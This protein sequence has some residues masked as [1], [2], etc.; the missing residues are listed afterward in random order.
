M[1]LNEAIEKLE[2][3]GLIAEMDDDYYYT[4][5]DELDDIESY[6]RSQMNFKKTLGQK[7]AEAKRLATGIKKLL[8]AKGW[9]AQFFEKEWTGGPCFYIRGMLTPTCKFY[10]RLEFVTEPLPTFGTDSKITIDEDGVFVR[11]RKI[12]SNP[13]LG[14]TCPKDIQKGYDK[15]L[16]DLKDVLN[17]IGG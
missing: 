3:A 8:N 6:H 10:A 9:R 17:S 11:T 13:N 12:D 4:S 5:K 1:E 7:Q 16:S 14:K 2:K 15:F